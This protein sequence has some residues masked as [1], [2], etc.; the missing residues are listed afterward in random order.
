MPID[1]FDALF[2]SAD[3]S[4][5]AIPVAVAGAADETVLRALRAAADRGWVAPLLA[6]A[7]VDVEGVAAAQ[8]ISLQGMTLLDCT[9]PAAEAVAQVRAGRARLL[10]KGQI[11][12]PALMQAV[13]DA[14][15]GLRTGRAI[16]QVVLMEIVPADRRFLLADTG[17]CPKPT[18]EQKIDILRSALA[19]A[20]ALGEPGARVAILAAS[21]KPTDALPDT[22]EAAQMQRRGEAGQW[23]GCVVQGPLS[24]DLAYAPEAGQRKRIAGPVAGAADVMLFPDLTS[25]NLT[26]KA[27]MCTADCRFGGVLCGTTCPVVFMSRADST[28][29]RLR[30][31]ALALKLLGTASL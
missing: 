29:T 26:V 11:P 7:R 19:V 22:H 13:L 18:L 31:L 17:I 28:E 16:C 2:R 27:I 9:N 3:N 10:M 6:G 1:G 5:G 14:R 4:P 30:S 20:Q 8:G 15:G 21:E 25:A 23:P 12:T 24:F